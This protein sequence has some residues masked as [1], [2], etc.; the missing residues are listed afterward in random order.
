MKKK[1]IVIVSIAALVTAI[2][3]AA[4]FMGNTGK[5]NANDNFDTLENMPEFEFDAEQ[6][7]D[8]LGMSEEE[9]EEYLNT[10]LGEILTDEQIESLNEALAENDIPDIDEILEDLG[11]DNY[12]CTDTDGN[13]V[14]MHVPQITDE[15]AEQYN[16]DF[17]AYLDALI[18][19]ADPDS[20][21]AVYVWFIS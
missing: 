2:I 18:A 5:T 1:S 7:A 17:E 4:L 14:I 20:L 12:L 15:E 19:G 10:P 21:E 11:D 16:K 8:N 13:E 3:A 6:A 9:L